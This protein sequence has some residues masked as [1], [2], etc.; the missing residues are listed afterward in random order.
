MGRFFLKWKRYGIL[1][2]F[3]YQFRMSNT[4]SHKLNIFNYIN[5]N[6]T[7][8]LLNKNINTFVYLHDLIL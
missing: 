8:I 1:Y 4:L 6:G 7:Q 2:Q 3:V 5:E